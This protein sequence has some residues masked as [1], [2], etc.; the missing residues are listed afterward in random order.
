MTRKIVVLSVGCLVAILLTTILT[1]AQTPAQRQA[2]KAKPKGA[3]KEPAGVAKPQGAN[4]TP[5]GIAKPK[6]P[7][8]VGPEGSGQRFAEPVIPGAGGIAQREMIQNVVM[9]L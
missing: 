4:R 9:D 2:G 7:E 8:L 5:V 1:S 3:S 6:G